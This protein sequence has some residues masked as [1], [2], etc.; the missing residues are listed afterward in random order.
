MRLLLDTHAFIWWLA[1]DPRLKEP[2]RAAI[3]DPASVVFVS[4]ATV[5]EIAIKAKLGRLD[6]GAA[7][8]AAEIATNGFIE[9]PISGQH[10]VAAGSLPLHHAD[11][12]DRMLVAQAALE[13]LVILTRDPLFRSYEAELLPT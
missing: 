1:D 9:L 7:D 13:K 8:A 6:L 2:A 12:F 5:W 4:A 11:P 3:S 10:A